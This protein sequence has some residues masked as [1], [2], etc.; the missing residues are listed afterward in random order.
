MLTDLRTFNHSTYLWNETDV[1]DSAFGVFLTL[2]SKYF[3]EN[4]LCPCSS[5]LLGEGIFLFFFHQGNNIGF[6]E[7]RTFPIFKMFMGAGQWLCTPSIPAFRRHWEANLCVKGQP[8]LQN[9]FQDS[10][11]YTE[12]SCLRKKN[13]E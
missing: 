9:E 7:N 5:D 4:I 12:R 1:V 10:Q 6:I 2:V 11:G 8:E 3:I 13:M